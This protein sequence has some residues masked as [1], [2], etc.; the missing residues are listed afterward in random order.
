MAITTLT[1]GYGYWIQAN[2]LY[3]N[4]EDYIDDWTWY[5]GQWRQDYW[6]QSEYGAC[7][8]E[9]HVPVIEDRLLSRTITIPITFYGYTGMCEVF[10]VLST[11]APDDSLDF[12]YGPTGGVISDVQKTVYEDRDNTVFSFTVDDSI[13]LSGKTIY[14]YMYHPNQGFGPNGPNSSIVTKTFSNGT[15][16]YS[17]PYSLTVNAGKGSA[18]TVNRTSSSAGQTGQLSSGAYLYYG[19]KLKI[20]FS[21]NTNY[22][23]LTTTV[24]SASFVSGNLHTVSDNVLVES[25]AQVLASNVGATD[26]DIESVSTITV[27]KYNTNYYH[28]L[29]YEFGGKTGYI[30]SSG[31]VQSSETKFN[32]TS[33]AFTVPKSFYDVIP[34]EKYGTC[35]ITCRTY[36]TSTSKTVLGTATTC[37]F[38]AIAA[39]SKC[40]PIISAS[41]VDINDVTKMLTGDES[42][43][44]KYK[45]TALCTINA[46]S[47]NKSTIDNVSIDGVTHSVS[48]SASSKINW[49]R[50]IFD[51]SKSSIRFSATDSRGYT[52]SQTV[53]PTIVYYIPLTCNPIVARKTPTGSEM[54]IKITGKV[55]RGSFGAYS[56][57]LK[58]QYRYREIA[59]SYG[60]WK[61]ID[62][63]DILFGTS[64]Y[65]TDGAITI[66]DSFDYKKEYEFD[67]RALD[68]AS[69]IILSV[70][71]QTIT[72]QKGIPVFDW[73]ENDF[74]V[75]VDLRILNT[76][77]LDIIYPIGSVYISTLDS[78]PQAL[79]VGD[80]SW[81]SIPK[82]GDL[83][84]WRRIIAP[85][86]PPS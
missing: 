27:T 9:Y 63:S 60:D 13:S 15:L 24:N 67:V 58:L 79:T 28:S 51:A 41:I 12:R 31:G 57:T 46:E 56:N 42:V 68:G 33:V 59:G 19:D 72:V 54:T 32:T 80:M 47:R 49:S 29:Q 14:L 84:C 73:G 64:S 22:R 82:I 30:T 74:N 2:G 45:S 44:I 36:E 43:L 11:K 86:A 83:F 34:N 50:N 77:I 48:S 16:T 37:T 8:V 35:T 40:E 71:Q 26:A 5:I 39:Q 21:A 62:E 20:T 76:N 69:D 25:T 3:N 4:K 10:A 85:S 61:T 66:D 78:L 7:C 70:A 1:R 52:K 65:R 55:Y 75:N 38:I 6:T 23:L 17:A 18:I 53:N 81:V